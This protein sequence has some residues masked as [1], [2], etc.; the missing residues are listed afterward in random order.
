[1]KCD[2][3]HPLII[4]FLYD[5]ISTEDNQLLQKHLKA[6]AKCREELA[7]LKSTSN[8]L[9]KWEDEEPTFNLVM[10]SENVTRWETLKQWLKKW[11]PS[12][13]K[14]GL[15]LA[16]GFAGIF[17]LLAIANTEIS[18]QD[19][20]FNMRIALFSASKKQQQSGLSE[21][22]TQQIVQQIQR[23]NYYMMKAMI[24]QSE[25]EQKKEWATMLTR[26]NQ[27]LEQ[28]RLRDLSLIGA[29]LEDI[30]QNTIKKL[31][32]TDES[33]NELIRYIN[34]PQR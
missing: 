18:Y 20:Q 29:G 3:I 12:P 16:Y 8:I 30:E 11:L 7:H 32:R 13:K 22:Q 27:S 26:Y 9:Q 19:S 14:I 24:E 10:V 5:E 1:M 25:A 31:Q 4:D 15:G 17:L 6:C 33:L 23:D 2:Q 34:S 21:M 28:Q